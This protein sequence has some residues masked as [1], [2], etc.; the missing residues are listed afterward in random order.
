LSL[1]P[2]INNLIS[3]K[4]FLSEFGPNQKT[5]IKEKNK[6]NLKKNLKIILYSN[7][8]NHNE[9]KLGIYHV[10]K[11]TVCFCNKKEQLKSRLVQLAIQKI[12]K[13][14]DYLKISKILVTSTE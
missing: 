2:I 7:T 5:E 1:T 13:N 11:M 8:N 6:E 9:I 3:E 4:D 12:T 14:L 10:L